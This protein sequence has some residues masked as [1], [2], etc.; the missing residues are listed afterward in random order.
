MEDLDKFLRIF[1]ENQTSMSL[2]PHLKKGEIA[3]V[4]HVKLSSNFLTDCSKA[5]LVLWI[6]LAICV[7][8]HTVLSVP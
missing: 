6:L 8:Y 7:S 5:V 2:D 1:H 3:T 4:R